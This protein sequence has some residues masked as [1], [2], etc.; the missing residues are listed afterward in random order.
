M[1]YSHA[2]DLPVSCGL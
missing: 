2:S 1:A